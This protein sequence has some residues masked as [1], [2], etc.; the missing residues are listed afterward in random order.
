[1]SNVNSICNCTNFQM[2]S[3]FGINLCNKVSALLYGCS[4]LLARWC[5]MHYVRMKRRSEKRLDGEIMSYFYMTTGL[6]P[7]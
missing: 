1:M 7:C 6:L 2:Y 5:T 4:Y 3:S